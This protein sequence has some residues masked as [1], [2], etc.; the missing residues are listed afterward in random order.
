MTLFSSVKVAKIYMFFS[1]FLVLF[2]AVYEY[3]SFGVYSYFMIYA[4]AVPMI[5]GV[6]PALLLNGSFPGGNI[7]AARLWA[8]GVVTLSTG[9]IF[10]G[11]ID[12]YGTSSS[13]FYIYMAIG[14]ILLSAAILISV[15]DKVA[16][17]EE[18]HG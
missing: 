11:I 3:F 15:Y 8:Y 7:W 13:M 9:A 18:S 6:L 12:I 1:L 17:K 4:F 16:R 14:I 5:L 2:G 10:R